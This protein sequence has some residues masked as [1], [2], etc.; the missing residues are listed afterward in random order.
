MFALMGH[1]YLDVVVTAAVYS[2]TAVDFRSLVSA[3]YLIDSSG[4]NTS[5]YQDDHVCVLQVGPRNQVRT[6]LSTNRTKTC[7]K[8]QH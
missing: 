8:T 4:H 6:N 5:N 2:S 3:V 7:T 1:L